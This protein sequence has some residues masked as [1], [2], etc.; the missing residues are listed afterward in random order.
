AAGISENHDCL[1]TGFLAQEVETAANETGFTFSGVDAPDNAGDLYGL[2]YAEFV[3]PLVKAVQEQQA[4]IEELQRE[5][6]A[7]DQGMAELKR[8]LE[9]LEA[10][11]Q[12]P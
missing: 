3:V 6:A 1:Y 11:A 9:R 2:R 12:R 5:I 8:R 4:V 10:G 7:R